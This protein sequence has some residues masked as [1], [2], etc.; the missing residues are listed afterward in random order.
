MPR[1][2]PRGDRL[3]FS[4]SLSPA[5]PFACLDWLGNQGGAQAPAA[6]PSRAAAEF[7][8]SN[9]VPSIS[10]SSSSFVQCRIDRGSCSLSSPAPHGHGV[11]EPFFFFFLLGEKG[12]REKK[13]KRD[14]AMATS[15]RVRWLVRLFHVFSGLKDFFFFSF[16]L[17]IFFSPLWLGA[18]KWDRRDRAGQA[19]NREDNGKMGGTFF[20][21]CFLPFFVPEDGLSLPQIYRI[22]DAI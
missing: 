14:G 22:R 5:Q 13:R 4:L 8:F 12:R 17:F 6:T 18:G 10:S 16:L 20:H 15:S 19:G 11:A 21:V 1:S 3:C 7:A 9:L 2:S